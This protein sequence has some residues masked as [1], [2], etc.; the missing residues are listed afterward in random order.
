M[1]DWEKR[2]RELIPGMG[3]KRV[4]MEDFFDELVVAV[5]QLGKEMT[6]ERL[7]EVA[8]ELPNLWRAKPELKDD[9]SMYALLQASLFIER[10]AKQ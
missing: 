2:A 7:G 3:P 10:K 9:V 1:T 5:L 4:K 8:G 6:S